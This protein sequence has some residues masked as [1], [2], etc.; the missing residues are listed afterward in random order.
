MWVAIRDAS[1][2]YR[3]RL[4][5]GG[6]IDVEKIRQYVASTHSLMLYY[7]LGSA[8]SYLLVISEG[9]EE[10]HELEIPREIHT[11]D[12]DLPKGPLTRSTVSQIVAHYLA[13]IGHAQGERGILPGRDFAE[14]GLLADEETTYLAGILVPPKV[15]N[16]VVKV[17]PTTVIIVPDGALH[18]LPFQALVVQKNNL[19]GTCWTFSR[20]LRTHHRPAS[21]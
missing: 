6:K 13:Q 7:C 10:F 18:Q 21:Y 19:A 20:P 2:L 5:S 3:Q 9:L 8:R 12:F 17:K 16:L 14:P 11:S 4:A 1:P 15:Q